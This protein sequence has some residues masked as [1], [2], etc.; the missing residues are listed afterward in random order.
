MIL[1]RPSDGGEQAD[2]LHSIRPEPGRSGLVLLAL[3]IGCLPTLMLLFNSELALHGGAFVASWIV[4]GTGTLAATLMLLMRSGVRL[5]P[6]GLAGGRAP[7]WAYLGG[8]TGAVNVMIS[9]MAVNLGLALSGTQA[10]TLS[11]QM[12]F[13]HAADR[14]GIFGLTRRRLV[15]GDV[16]AVLLIVA[17]SLLIILFGTG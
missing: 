14:W 8:C 11:G 15:W 12:L 13:S 7:Y 10:L 1:H 6:S 16:I 3:A 2:A 9:A 5:G 17:G 4:H